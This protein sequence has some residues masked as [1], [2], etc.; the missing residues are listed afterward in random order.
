VTASKMSAELIWPVAIEQGMRFAIREAG[1]HHR[2][3]SVSKIVAWRDLI[4]VGGRQWLTPQNQP[5]YGQ[6]SW[7][8]RFASL[9]PALS[10]TPAFSLTPARSIDN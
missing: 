9:T 2:C 10:L 6:C 7:K 4:G 8:D 5:F 1:R 3:R